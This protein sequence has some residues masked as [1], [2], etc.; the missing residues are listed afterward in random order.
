SCFG[1]GAGCGLGSDFGSGL[2]VGLGSGGGGGGGGG[3]TA[4]GAACWAT[5]DHNSTSK[6]GFASCFQCTPQVRA[7]INRTWTK[8]AR[9]MG[10]SHRPDRGGLNSLLSAGLCMSASMAS[11]QREACTDR[12]TRSTPARCKV[13]MTL[14]TVSYLIDLSALITTGTGLF[15]P[16]AA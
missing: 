11:G 15:S 7:A 2:G 8:T 5:G 13:S 16:A 6:L 1:G 12:P 14:T 3:S 10:P 4:L 9:P